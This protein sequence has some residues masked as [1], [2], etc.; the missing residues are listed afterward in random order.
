[1]ASHASSAAEKLRVQGS[2]CNAIPVFTQTNRFRSQ[3]L[4][5]GGSTVIPLSNA[6][7]HARLLVRAALFGLKKIYRGGFAYKKANVMLMEIGEAQVAQGSLLLEPSL[8]ARSK[9]LMQARDMLNARYGR[10]TLSVFSSSVLK[11][12]PC[13]GKDVAVLHHEMERCADS[14]AC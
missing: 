10:N 13:A 1:V 4:Q 2:V 14:A 12:W 7:A 11:P 6:S 3:D 8:G 5:Y 9:R